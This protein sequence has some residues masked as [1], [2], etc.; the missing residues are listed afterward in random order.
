MEKP[1]VVGIF[2]KMIL[3]RVSGILS[4]SFTQMDV[5]TNQTLELEEYKKDLVNNT[6]F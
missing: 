5:R 2:P 1:R 3:F 4:W 6:H